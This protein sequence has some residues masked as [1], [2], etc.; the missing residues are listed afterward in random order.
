MTLVK[1]IEINFKEV[2]FEMNT[3]GNKEENIMEMNQQEADQREYPEQNYDYQPGR[4]V[5][6][7]LFK[8]CLLNRRKMML[9]LLCLISSKLLLSMKRHRK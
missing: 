8:T 3:E 9:P 1:V 2:I 7:T 4:S 5:K 6:I